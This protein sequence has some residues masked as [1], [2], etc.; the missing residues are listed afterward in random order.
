MRPPIVMYTIAA[1]V[2]AVGQPAHGAP[3]AAEKC[4]AAK[5]SATGK[6]S[7]CRMQAEAKVE[8]TGKQADFSKCSAKHTQAFQKTEAKY[9]AE[10]PTISDASAIQVAVG[11]DTSALSCRVKGIFGDGRASAVVAATG[12]AIVDVQ[13]IQVTNTID[14]ILTVTNTTDNAI[15]AFCF[16]A[17]D[18]NDC[19]S[20]SHSGPNYSIIPIPAQS[21]VSWLAGVGI[22]LL[23]GRTSVP[24]SGE[25]VCFQIDP[26][27]AETTD[28]PV[29][30]ADLMA[31]I[32]RPGG[33]PQSGIDIGLGGGNNGDAILTLGGSAYEYGPCP[34]SIGVTRI[35]TCWSLASAF[36]FECH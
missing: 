13:G 31:S 21:S 34:A 23:I 30:R 6:F 33:C 8:K 3:T 20:F 1:V 22:P 10:C 19:L 16:F 2:I 36:H 27:V 18:G 25:M 12:A 26:S 35:E 17:P 7:L 15:A 32:T 5:I 28:R 14:P 11:V 29:Y 4:A 9:G 24:F